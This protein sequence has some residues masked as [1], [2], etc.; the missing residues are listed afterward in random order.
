MVDLA[1][2]IGLIV[3]VLCA[4]DLLILVISAPA[5]FRALSRAVSRWFRGK[6][7]AK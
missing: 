5:I 3:V 1:G 6:N 7:A 4:L 2:D